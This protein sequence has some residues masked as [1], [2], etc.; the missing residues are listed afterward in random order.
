M[1][2]YHGSVLI[3][4]LTTQTVLRERLPESVLRSFIGGTGLASYLLYRHC[5]PG[6]DPLGPDNPLIFAC[7]PL[8]GS[9]S[10]PPASSP[11]QPNRRSP[12]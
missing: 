12:A 1:Y 9:S 7:S 2:G 11:S 6:A 8:I 5:P 10:P 3:V 4:D